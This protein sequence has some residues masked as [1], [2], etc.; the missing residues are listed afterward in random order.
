MK[1][2]SHRLVL[3]LAQR[4]FFSNMS[5]DIHYKQKPKRMENKQKKKSYLHLIQLQKSPSPIQIT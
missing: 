4:P 3:A 1:N 2:P 5:R